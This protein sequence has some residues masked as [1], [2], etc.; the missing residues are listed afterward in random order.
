MTRHAEHA[1][2]LAREEVV[3]SPAARACYDQNFELPSAVFR[4]MAA[5]FFGFLARRATPRNL[6]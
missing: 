5:L 4:A 1:K 2:F 3:S 6:P